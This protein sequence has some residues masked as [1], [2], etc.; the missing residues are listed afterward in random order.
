MGLLESLTHKRVMH[1][2]IKGKLSPRYIDPYRILS[3]IGK[4]AYELELHMEL[5]VM[6]H[7]FHVSMLKKCNNPEKFR[8]SKTPLASLF[9]RG[10]IVI[11]AFLYLP[12]VL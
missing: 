8:H 1:F 2:S 9:Y 12:K 6:H 4:V 5:A 11:S 3:I 7:V 10:R